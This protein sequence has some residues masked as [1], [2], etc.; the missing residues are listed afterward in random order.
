MLDS[1]FHPDG[2]LLVP[3]ELARGPW[4]SNAQHGG[5]P[6]AILGRAIERCEPQE[7]MAVARIS[8]DLLRPIPLTPLQPRAQIVRDGRRVPLIDAELLDGD[9]VVARASAWRIRAGEDLAPSV[10]AG[11]TPPGPEHGT[12]HAPYRDVPGFWTA[13]E[14]HL[15]VGTFNEVGAATGWAR[16]TVPIVAGEDPSPLQRVLAAADFGNGISSVVDYFEH[17][18]VNVELTVHLFRYPVGEW[19]CLEAETSSDQRGI[20]VARST[21]FDTTGQI[22]TGAQALLIDRRPD[23]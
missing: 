18:F 10:A 2:D 13:I 9:Q 12:K 15:V 14:W 19:V 21:L 22:G 23:R 17:L 8:V 4:D 16:L 11:T 3:T 20:G 7:G 6:A 1:V 5:A